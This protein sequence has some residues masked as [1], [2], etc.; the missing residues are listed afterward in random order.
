MDPSVATATAPI[1]FERS[2]DIGSLFYAVYQLFHGAA[3][4]NPHSLGLIL[5][6]IWVLVGV[7]AYIAC[8]GFLI[9]FAFATIELHQVKEA[10]HHRYAT[11]EVEK[12]EEETEHHRWKHVAALVE[13]PHEN[14]WRQAIIEADIMLDD[15]LATHGY[16][17]A[18]VGEKLKQGNPA[19]FHTL[20]DAW[21]AH[22]VRNDI[23]HQG[24]TYQLTGQLAYRT[25]AKYR[26]VFEEFHAI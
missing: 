3:V 25:V 17:G 9:A 13:S 8:F 16:S 2:L 23:A 26:N 10:E 12:A 11:I 19:V 15:I 21:D 5:S 6:N 4:S 14:D 22:K 18:S 20:Q 24:S 7:L 1:G